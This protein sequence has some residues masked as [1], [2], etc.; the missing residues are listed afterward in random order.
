MNGYGSPGVGVPCL[1]GVWGDRNLMAAQP[2]KF[3]Q[4]R[5][6]AGIF[7]DDEHFQRGCLSLR[8]WNQTNSSFGSHSNQS[9]WARA[10]RG[11]VNWI[12]VGS[13][14]A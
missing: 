10:D 6:N 14:L 12:T 4:H 2:E 3:G 13:Q 1:L 11:E 9:R 8:W 7:L 5:P